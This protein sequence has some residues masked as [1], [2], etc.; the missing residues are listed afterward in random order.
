MVVLNGLDVRAASSRNWRRALRETMQPMAPWFR[1]FKGTVRTLDDVRKQGFGISRK[2]RCAASKAQLASAE[3]SRPAPSSA[4]WRCGGF[5]GM[6]PWE[7]P[8]SSGLVPEARPG[9]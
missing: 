6:K 4:W 5:Q 9:Y 8:L 2:Q 3:L 7:S 1:G